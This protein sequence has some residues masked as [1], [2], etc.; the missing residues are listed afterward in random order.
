M[1]HFYLSEW[2]FFIFYLL[3]CYYGIIVVVI[4]MMMMTIIINLLLLFIQASTYDQGTWIVPG[5][6]LTGKP[7]PGGWEPAGTSWCVD[8]G[9]GS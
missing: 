8:L 3:R 7:L 1:R 6:V 9:R 5:Q 2:H 4:I